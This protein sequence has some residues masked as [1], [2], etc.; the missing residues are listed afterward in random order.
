MRQIADLPC[1]DQATE[2]RLRARRFRCVDRQCVTRIFTE[3]FPGSV[4]AKARRTNR[5]S[6]AQIAIGFTTGGERRGWSLHRNETHHL[7]THTG[8][9]HGYFGRY[10]NSNF[11]R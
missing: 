10:S 8:Y 9:P 4:S 11:P 2:I 7:F 1:Q 6:T 3:R 5:L